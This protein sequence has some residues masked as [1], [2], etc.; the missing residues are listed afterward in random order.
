[1]LLLTLAVTPL[2][3]LT[4]WHW[5]VQAAPHARPVRILLRQPAFA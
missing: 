3:Q 4:G 1:M 2:R 5:L